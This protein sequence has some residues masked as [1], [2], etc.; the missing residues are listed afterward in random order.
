MAYYSKNY[1]NLQALAQLATT[2]FV[3]LQCLVFNVV[4][5]AFRRQLIDREQ[6]A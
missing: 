3:S 2:L 6:H 5:N 1:Y 4:N